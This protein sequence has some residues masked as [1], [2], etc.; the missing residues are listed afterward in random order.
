MIGE[1]LIVASAATEDVQARLT[2]A[3]IK[4]RKVTAGEAFRGQNRKGVGLVC[5]RSPGWEVLVSA[6]APEGAVVLLGDGPTPD[7]RRRLGDADVEVAWSPKDVSDALARAEMR[8]SARRSQ[9]GRERASERMEAISTVNEIAQAIARQGDLSRIIAEAIRRTD[10]LCDADGSALLLVDPATGEL[11]FDVVTGESAQAVRTVRLKPGQGIAGKVASTTAPLCIP[12]VTQEPSFDSRSDAA[13]GFKTGSI[14]AVPL[15]FGGDL[16]GVLEAVR[17]RGRPP[18]GNDELKRLA[19]LAPHVA[20]AVHNGQITAE[21]RRAQA[22]IL[23]ANQALEEKVQERTAQIARAKREWEKTFDAISEPMALLDGFTVRRSNLAYARRAGLPIQSIP[24]K[25]CHELLAGRATPCPGCPLVNNEGASEIQLK[26]STFQVA[27]FQVGDGAERVVH[28]RDVSHERALENRL[29]ETERLAAVG[30]LASGAAHEINNPLGF[31]SSNL[32][33]LRRNLDEL[34]E[35]GVKGEAKELLL[36]C[37]EMVIESLDGARRVAEIVKGLRE[38]SR[39]EIGGGTHT[40]VSDCVTRA[41]RAELPADPRVTVDLDESLAVRVDPLKLDQVLM[42]ILR[43]A[44]QAIDAKGRIRIIARR[45][46]A[47]ATIRV[48]DDG[49]GIA[50]ENV[51]RVFEPFFTTRGVGKGIGLGLTA[52]WGIVTRFGG[53]IDV[54]SVPGRGSAFIVKLPADTDPVP[55]DS[56]VDAAA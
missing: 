56:H 51:R 54:E 32:Q 21:L 9:G 29:R 30:Q 44:R 39:Q 24:G 35:Q 26:E 22:Q 10:E 12:D 50:P 4:S 16:V 37:E 48:E 28:Y 11:F 45:D 31:L 40:K 15:L 14:V 18:L 43:N 47:L 38:L 23:N 2:R 49:A 8:A 27:G 55:E 34:G 36:E 17:S 46:A 41:V 19:L 52:A 53:R 33:S 6:F 5:D 20:I 42:Q 7:E 1:V 13:S 25:T 3:G